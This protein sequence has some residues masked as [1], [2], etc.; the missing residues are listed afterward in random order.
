MN[1]KLFCKVATVTVTLYNKVTS[2]FLK[3]YKYNRNKLDKI[4]YEFNIK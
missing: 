3:S 2:H 4:A 1:S